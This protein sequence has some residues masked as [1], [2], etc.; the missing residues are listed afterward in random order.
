MESAVHKQGS[1]KN[2]HQNLAQ[3][4]LQRI[5]EALQHQGKAVQQRSQR[6]MRL[7]NDANTRRSSAIESAT[8]SK[9]REAK[10]VLLLR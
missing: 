10:V 9:L 4:R 6:L 7:L 8:A 3:A 5:L 1:K 2:E